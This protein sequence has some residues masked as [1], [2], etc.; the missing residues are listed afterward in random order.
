MPMPLFVGRAAELDWLAARLSTAV[1]SRPS[2]VVI[3]GPPGIGKSALVSTFLE[4]L[5]DIRT[6]R[7]SGDE[8]ETFLAFGVAHQLLGSPED[9][10]ED[11]YAAGAAVLED[12]DRLGDRQA[13]AIVVD[14][15]HLADAMSLAAL[16]F[17]LRRLAADPVLAIFVTRDD[18]V[19]RLPAGLLR[20]ADAHGNRLHLHGLNET[21]VDELIQAR[22]LGDH[23]GAA[24][25]RLHRHTDGSP[26]YLRALL[27]ELPMETLLATRP[28]P[29]PPSYAL[30]VTGALSAHSEPAQRLAR[31][32]AILEDG[33]DIEL[34]AAV[35]GVE[36]PQRVLE[37]LSRSPAI[38]THTESPGGWIVRFAHP[39]VRAAVYDDLGP[40]ARQTLH[41]RAAEVVTGDAALRHM[42]AASSGSDDHLADR[43]AAAAAAK[44]AQGDAHSA[45]DLTLQA[46]R[47]GTP[48]T[49][50]DERL[51]DAVNLY[52][53]DGNLATTKTLADELSLTP[54]TAR[55][56]YLQARL[57]W[58]AGKPDE[59]ESLATEAWSRGDELSPE[60]LGSLAA[61]LSQLHNLRADGLGAAQWAARALALGLP[62]DLADS[63]NAAQA[64]GLALVG[65]IE[66][67]MGVLESVP[68]DPT[69]VRGYSH[70]LIARGALRVATDDLAGARGD[71]ALVCNARNAEVSPQRLL[72]MGA[73]A[74]VEFRLGS[75]DTSL[76]YAEHALSLA[77]DT[78]QLWVQGYLHTTAVLVCA[79]RGDWLQAEHHLAASRTLAEQLGDLATYVVSENAGVHIAWCRSDP[80]A[81][82]ARSAL[83]LSLGGGP[84]HEPGWLAWPVQYV[85]ALIEL[86]RLDEA[87]SQ[88]EQFEALAR[89]RGCQSR[90]AALARV[91]GE[92]ATA[93]RDHQ[94]ARSSFRAA[95]ELDQG[96]VSALDAALGQAAF[97]RFLRR[98]GEKRAAIQRLEDAKARLDA[99]GARPMVGRVEDEL[100]ACGVTPNRRTVEL[101]QALTPQERTVATLVCQGLTNQEVA[102]RLVLSVK[103]VG[104]HLGNVYTK[105]G[106]HS[107]T[108]LAAA[109]TADT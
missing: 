70:Q 67:A 53:I 91:R 24:A 22:G 21:E 42:V 32:A 74:E 78:E 101:P 76:A 69:L 95:L 96:G 8:A 6:M 10:W 58:F 41:R 87:E 19:S 49:T 1:S 72:A 92:L 88:I 16:T 77:E 105:L 100:A 44:L 15:A 17:A 29:A 11:Q 104:Y 2:V 75:W 59:A 63:T 90:L 83:L 56:V 23:A 40:H 103:T 57:A 109:W 64:F 97:G 36:H 54:P 47:V 62:P 84:T 81:V 18:Q 65:R 31:A 51:L 106:V 94:V 34:V 73:L 98:R 89:E 86:D 9:S 68:S 55:R 33:S 4:G 71:L 7:A 82:V 43:L 102:Q 85:S 50:S 79:C 107:R 14:D 99:L 30:L 35:A 12:L 66:E 60:H 61:V 108:R 45:A 93:R 80:D 39:L 46:S 37:E 38:L 26:L 25:I 52:L 20:L 48:G 27:D 13:T 3:D 5:S 28:L